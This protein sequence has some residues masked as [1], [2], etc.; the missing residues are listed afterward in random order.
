VP[1]VPIPN[2]Q[3]SERARNFDRSSRNSSVVRVGV[4]PGEGVGPELTSICVR[5]LRRL[6]DRLSFGVEIETG[7]PIGLEARKACGEDLPSSAIDFATGTF[8]AG[9]A[10]LAGPGGGRFVYDMR[11][12][13]DLL[14]KINPL[15]SFRGAVHGRPPFDVVVVRDNIE[16]LYQGESERAHKNGVEVVLHSFPTS[17]TAVR[18]VTDRAARLAAVRQG[19]LT[20]V[21]KESGLPAVTEIWR[22]AGRESARS[23]DVAVDFIDID[24]AC[25]KL[26]REPHAFDVVATPN[27]FGDILS[28]LGGLVMGSRGVT[29]GA[30]FD[31][32]GRGVYQTNH[33][34]AHDLAGKGIA[35]PA[36][37]ILSLA[38]MLRDS[39][40]R[41][42]EADIIE[43][44]VESVWLEGL[45][46]ADMDRQGAGGPTIRCGTEEFAR[47]VEHHLDAH[48]EA[49]A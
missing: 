30:S 15:R 32:G 7:G 36:G 34:S 8:E 20:V 24:F 9:G 3:G 6:G 11:R 28:D 12:R 22:E 41:H 39:F 40:G 27:C 49:L 23:H 37:Q 44:S 38:M 45:C 2:T 43:R 1:D 4:F 19:R 48:A 31:A 5:M 42:R 47:R 18:A 21:A 26:V 17:F 14:L 46:T 16:G 25:Y 13:L 33:G 35:N 10:I 29:Y